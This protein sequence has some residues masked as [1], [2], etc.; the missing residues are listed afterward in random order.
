MNSLKGSELTAAAAKVKTLEASLSSAEEELKAEK[1]SKVDL[2][3]N[4][5]T[6]KREHSEELGEL[7][8]AVNDLKEKE[9]QLIK[10]RDDLEM[11]TLELEKLGK[12]LAKREE[13]HKAEMASALEKSA[14]EA[15]VLN[16]KLD[17]AGQQISYLKESM[18]GSKVEY[19]LF[20][21][22]M[23]KELE[24]RNEH[25][26]AELEKQENLVKKYKDE[27]A[28]RE[29]E[30][31]FVKEELKEKTEELQDINTDLEVKEASFNNSFKE[32]EEQHREEVEI[33]VTKVE[34]AKV[35]ISELREA[36]ARARA[37][38]DTKLDEIKVGRKTEVN[39]LQ[40]QLS[41]RDRTILDLEASVSE[42][43][44][45]VQSMEASATDEAK[46][47]AAKMTKMTSEVE[48]LRERKREVESALKSLQSDFDQMSHT[49]E[50]LSVKIVEK[51][52]QVSLSYVL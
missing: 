38:H 18:A 1:A 50:D 16:K 30:L 25:S 9:D 6:L 2:E 42:L 37:E 45:K 51:E 43:K 46:V 52:R 7:V 15:E 36:A 11:A 22:K 29:E 33:L 35:E 34:E 12:D 48:E 27:L 13:G 4:L 21:E 40:D 19:D 44:S 14:K 39:S 8:D 32:N 28:N 49:N 5:G 41:E 31:E 3:Q 47:S 20:S 24:A 26:Q 17:E 10:T 23:N